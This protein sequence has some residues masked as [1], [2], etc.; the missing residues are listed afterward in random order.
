MQQGAEISQAHLPLLMGGTRPRSRKAAQ[1]AEAWC[2][3][4]PLGPPGA[5][6]RGCP[7]SAA[8]HRSHSWSSSPGEQA[9]AC[10]CWGC[11]ALGH[12]FLLC[13]DAAEAR[14]MSCTCRGL[15]LL[16][17]EGSTTP[18]W[19]QLPKSMHKTVIFTEG[20]ASA[21]DYSC[22]VRTSQDSRLLTHFFH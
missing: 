13:R 3:A 10:R 6:R 5:T 18:Q 8:H 16:N 14:G 12:F 7:H 17:L 22:P 15:V 20:P 1:R 21:L 11:G 2:K 4:E 19:Q 9:M